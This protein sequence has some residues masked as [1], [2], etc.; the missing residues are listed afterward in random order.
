MKVLKDETIKKLR[1]L[2][3]GVMMAPWCGRGPEVMKESKGYTP[4]IRHLQSICL[5]KHGPLD[6]L[7]AQFIAETRNVLPQLLDELERLRAMEK[8]VKEQIEWDETAREKAKEEM[9]KG[10]A[11]L[12]MILFRTAMHD[13]A[14]N[15]LNYVLTGEPS[16]PTNDN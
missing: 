1:E 8:R 6:H 15:R 9:R 16:E 14:I 11:S 2:E 5:I 7:T 10:G 4:E 3:N 12:K 13:A